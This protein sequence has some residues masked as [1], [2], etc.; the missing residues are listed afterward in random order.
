MRLIVCGGRDYQDI[1]TAFRVLNHLHRLRNITCVI[2][3]C[4]RGADSIGEHWADSL[5][6]P[7]ARFPARWEVHG[8]SAGPIRNGQMISEGRAEAVFAFPGGAGTANMVRQAKA[9][10]LKVWTL[11]DD[12]ERIEGGPKNG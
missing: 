11:S 8:K 4:A 12:W 6:I 5:G 2:S 10:D 9:A 3:G 1:L 7:V